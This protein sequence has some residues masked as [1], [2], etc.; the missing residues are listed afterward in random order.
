MDR[1]WEKLG[2]EVPEVKHPPSEY[3]RQHC[4][5]TTQ[6]MEEPSQRPFFQQMLDA[7]DM[8]SYRVEKRAMQK[9]ILPDQDAEIGDLVEEYYRSLARSGNR[10]GGGN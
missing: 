10:P 1:A 9:I 3:I 2:S 7:I 5:F 4:W 6:P 8:D